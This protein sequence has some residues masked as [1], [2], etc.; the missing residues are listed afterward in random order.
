MTIVQRS[1]SLPD[2]PKPMMA[3][4]DSGSRT[5]SDLLCASAVD[6]DAF[7]LFFDRYYGPLLSYFVARVRSPEN[8]AD[9]CAETV[10][11]ALD[12]A[13]RFDSTLGSARQWL[14]GIAHHK[15]SRYWR[16]LRVSREARDRLGVAQ[17]TV[18]AAT[19]AAFTQ[20]EAG[21]DKGALFAA[22]DQLPTE[23]A[24]AVRLRVL[25]EL[26]YSEVA[27]RLGCRE[28]AA[29]VRVHRGLKRLEAEFEAG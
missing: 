11:A 18:D 6:P 9:L 1:T 5:D 28:G 13:A 24:A 12:G 14:Y 2:R 17:V 22:L 8:A 19:I 20:V 26:E 7:G 10:A 21:A 4:N 27:R 16:D 23:Q 15:L 25:E 3:D 29:R